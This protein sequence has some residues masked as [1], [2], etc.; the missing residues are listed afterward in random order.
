MDP[1][2]DVA[3]MRRIA[4]GGDAAAAYAHFCAALEPGHRAFQAA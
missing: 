1:A 3:L 4:R 2:T